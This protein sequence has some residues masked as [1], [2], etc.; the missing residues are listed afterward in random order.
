MAISMLRMIYG[1]KEA[2]ISTVQ[3]TVAWRILLLAHFIFMGMRPRLGRTPFGTMPVKRMMKSNVSLVGLNRDACVIKSNGAGNIVSDAAGIDNA[4]IANLTIIHDDTAGS[5]WRGDVDDETVVF[6]NCYIESDYIDAIYAISTSD[7]WIIGCVL[8]SDRYDVIYLH[9]D[10]DEDSSLTMMNSVVLSD[11]Y[12]GN[13][14][15]TM[16]FKNIFSA[17]IH[18]SFL[19]SKIIGTGEGLETLNL[20]D[21]HVDGTIDIGVNSICNLYNSSIGSVVASADNIFNAS[22]HI[23]HEA[24][25]I[26]A[27][28]TIGGDLDVAG[29]ADFDSGLFAVYPAD[30]RIG[31]AT[32][33]PRSG[34]MCFSVG[35]TVGAIDIYKT[36]G[37]GGG[38]ILI[39]EGNQM[40]AGFGDISVADSVGA[41]RLWDDAGTET[42]RL[43]ADTTDSYYNV[44]LDF[45]H[46]LNLP[47]DSQATGTTDGDVRWWRED[48]DPGWVEAY[49]G[50]TPGWLRVGPAAP[51][52][53]YLVAS[54]LYFNESAGQVIG[55]ATG[56]LDWDDAKLYKADIHPTTPEWNHFYFVP[57][58]QG[59]RDKLIARDDTYAIL[60][61]N[62]KFVIDLTDAKAALPAGYDEIR[63]ELYGWF[64]KK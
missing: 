56:G 64:S 9:G 42:I 54:G 35:S 37:V 43:R 2:P 1:R 62:T 20:Y 15:R 46:D 30:D 45:N 19:N 25:I 14:A 10:E 23:A 8:H 41:V 53:Y 32:A 16:Y 4:V 57:I 12:N 63:L 17:T 28:A 29:G 27:T 51:C 13:P 31:I 61:G 6:N 18:N 26:D 59:A 22:S 44:P 40:Q 49:C 34:K 39:Y 60:Q 55:E 5:V 33:A 38:G 52:P 3:F 24:I 7:L 48:A 36:D 21:T 58:P 47:D 11:V 50:D